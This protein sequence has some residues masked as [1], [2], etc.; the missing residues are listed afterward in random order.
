MYDLHVPTNSYQ[1][2]INQF[3]STI[4]Q[5]EENKDLAPNKKKKEKERCQ[6]MIDRLN[7]EQNKQ[8]EHTKRVNAR[9]QKEKEKWF[10]SEYLDRYSLYYLTHI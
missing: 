6:N 2:Q 10:Q 7:D 1:R 8:I 4:Q 5:V 3:K 9:M